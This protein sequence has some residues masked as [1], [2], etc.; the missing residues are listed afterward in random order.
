VAQSNPIGYN[1][2]PGFGGPFF[3]AYKQ[4]F[5][6]ANV[7]ALVYKRRPFLQD[8][9]KRDDFEGSCYAHTIMYE[10]PQGGSTS[11]KVALANQRASSR[12]ARMMIWR[13]REYQTIQIN[14]EEDRASRSNVG[15]LLKKKSYETKR[16]LEEMGRRIDIAAHGAGN[17]VIGSFTTGAAGSLGQTSL[18]LDQPGQIVRFSVGM[19]LQLSTSNFLDGTPA[20]LIGNTPGATAKVVAVQRSSGSLP[21]IITIDQALNTWAPSVAAT[22]QYFLLRAGDGVGFG[23]NVLDGGVSGL[24][25]WLPAPPV[26]GTTITNRLDPADNF[27]GTNRNADVQRLAGC[28]Y[29]AQPGDKYT[30]T[31]Q[32][33]GEELAV[34]GGGGED[35]N[36][37]LYVSPSDFT[38]YSLEL[39][40]NIRYMDLDEGAT[41]FKR[42]AVHTQ[43]GTLALTADP[44]IEPGLFYILD[45]STYYMKTLDAL[46]HMDT[47]DGNSSLRVSDADAQEIRWRGW[48]QL[49]FDEPGRNL[50]G[51][52]S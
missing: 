48:Y 13:G 40:P 50:V 8:C 11:Q 23:Q 26:P 36:M 1:G 47:A 49:I 38:G 25:A 9:T 45:R 32:Q 16:V 29:Q 22:T 41:G 31:Y 42:L 18:I 6:P 24:K 4:V 7:E 35:G 28:V 34:H 10:D 17:G 46:P 30:K 51:R 14:N 37:I 43:A 5:G 19:V 12:G 3:A 27:W 20:A 44:Q 52:S 39:G 15:A 33:A 2:D 21:S